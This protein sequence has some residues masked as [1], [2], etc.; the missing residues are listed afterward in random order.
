MGNKEFYQFPDQ[1]RPEF[2][3]WANLY[4]RLSGSASEG[5]RWYQEGDI[6]GFPGSYPLEIAREV[7]EHIMR[8]NPNNIMLHAKPS[9][10]EKDK[11][12]RERGAFGPYQDM[13]RE[14]ISMLANLLGGNNSKG[15]ISG[16]I[17]SGGTEANIYGI[18]L[19]R[20]LILAKQEMDYNSLAHIRVLVPRNAHYSVFKA[21][22]LLG[23]S[24][25]DEYGREAGSIRYVDLDE[26][27]CADIEDFRIKLEDALADKSVIGVIVVLTA[28]TTSAGQFDDVAH[29]A[30][31]IRS[32]K[33]TVPIY[34]H[35]DA[36]FAGLVTPFLDFDELAKKICPNIA[37]LHGGEFSKPV[38]DFNIEE[39]NSI[40]VD[41]HKMGLV[42]YPAG[43]VLFRDE[44]HRYVSRRVEYIAD[45][46]DETL[47]GSRPGAAAAACWAAFVHLGREGYKEILEDC[48]AK[49]DRIIADLYSCPET[50]LIGKP[51]INYF[52]FR[53][54]EEF[55]KS[56][57]SDRHKRWTDIVDEFCLVP[58]LCH[59]NDIEMKRIDTIEDSLK[60]LRTGRK[61]CGAE[62]ELELERQLENFRVY[63]MVIMPHVTDLAIKRFR[64]EFGKFIRQ[65]SGK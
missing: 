46:R 18:W 52:S 4:Q 39:V 31:I 35:V 47:I 55:V 15:N 40:T 45:E 10:F 60:E 22:N 20:N 49:A 5:L 23:L 25:T 61:P 54:K 19:G 51:R 43:V 24:Y 7:F 64:A 2:E 44:Y 58:S 48:M 59:R 11:E 63:R 62:R 29:A 12:E 27:Y 8:L 13:E 42:P 28:G 38:Y 65:A 57:D 14:V 33:A 53:F 56:W 9:T 36:A 26:N 32:T 21:C 34:L 16:Y 6:L 17:T 1:G 41:P 50:T 37:R 30:E 3:V